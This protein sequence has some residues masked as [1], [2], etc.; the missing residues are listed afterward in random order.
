MDDPAPAP[1]AARGADGGS[2]ILLVPYL[3]I[4]DFVRC[5]S[6]VRLLR[7][8][9]PDRPVDVLTSTLCAPLLDY[10]PGIRQG[11]VCDLPRSRLALRQ[12]WALAGRLRAQRYGSAV[13]M[14]RTWKSAL[15]PFLAGIPQRIGFIGEQRFWLVND[16]R[17]GER[18]LQR[19]IDRLGALALPKGAELPADWPA[20][21]VAV[22][23]DAVAAWRDRQRLPADGR[24]VVALAPGASGASLGPGA[25]R[26]PA[27]HYAELAR[28]LTAHGLDVWV[29]GGPAEAAMAAQIAAAGGPGVRDLTGTDLRNAIIAL[30]AADAAVCNDSGLMHVAAASGTP[31]IGIFGP[32]SPWHWGPLNPLAMALEPASDGPCRQCGKR[33]CG[34][35]R[36]RRTS[37]IPVDRVVD[38]V[39]RT[40]GHA[41]AGPGA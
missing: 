41:P 18:R 13:I 31:T 26:W 3:W 12:N 20:P 36:H 37:D 9:W 10:M 7:A 6:V 33:D 21:E 40:V 25:K 11:I 17:R 2:P 4:G 15:A 24:P 19:M 39:M 32:T 8:R 14:P 34:N 29:L 27:E 1:P 23:A 28:R 22:P 30:K 35:V 16:A 5:H 38:A